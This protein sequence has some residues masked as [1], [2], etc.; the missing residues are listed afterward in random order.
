[1]TKNAPE[2]NLQI[3]FQLILIIK[4]YHKVDCSVHLNSSEFW[5][6]HAQSQ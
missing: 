3:S 5:G 4:A 6:H 2:R 1:V